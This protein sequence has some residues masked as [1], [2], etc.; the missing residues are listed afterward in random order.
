MPCVRDF[1]LGLE[2]VFLSRRKH[3]AYKE[4]AYCAKSDVD[5]VLFV[6]INRLLSASSYKPVVLGV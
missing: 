4:K 2:S 6:R 1:T 3:V 5:L